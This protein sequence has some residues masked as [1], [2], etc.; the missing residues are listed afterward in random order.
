VIGDD[1][2]PFDYEVRPRDS[3]PLPPENTPV[4]IYEEDYFVDVTIGYF[5]G[6]TLRSWTGS[7]DIHV[8]HWRHIVRPE[9]PTA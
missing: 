7:D 4:W 1:W 5:D 3:Q 6:F 2:V 9:P 8:T